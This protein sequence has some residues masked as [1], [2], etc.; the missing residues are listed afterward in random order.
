VQVLAEGVGGRSV[1]AVL[2]NVSQTYVFA[3]SF[4]ATLYDAQGAQVGVFSMLPDVNL[5]PG[6]MVS[7][8]GGGDATAP[9]ARFILTL[10]PDHFACAY[11]VLKMSKV[12]AAVPAVPGVWTKTETTFAGE[13]PGYVTGTLQVPTPRQGLTAQALLYDS[14]GHLTGMATGDKLTAADGP[15]PIHIVFDESFTYSGF[16]NPWGAVA[17]AM[18]SAYDDLQ[19][20]PSGVLGDCQELTAG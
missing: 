17:T 4:K 11:P 18:V 10:N 8:E 1:G 2:K 7:I 20:L 15:T 19:T 16:P 5:L 6:E 14:A 9:A 13:H 12:P 3:F